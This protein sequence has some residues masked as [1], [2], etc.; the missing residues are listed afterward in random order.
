DPL[1]AKAGHRAY[2]QAGI[3]AQGH[4]I[5]RAGPVDHVHIAGTQVR[6]AHA[7]I[8]D[9]PESDAGQPDLVAVVVEL[10]LDQVD[11][12][13]A[14]FGGEG[15]RPYADRVLREVVAVALQGGGRHHHAGPV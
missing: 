7:V 9:G 2:D 1:V 8:G 5:L 15:E 3:D 11:L 14:G 13:R 10:R 12:V 4:R 6:G